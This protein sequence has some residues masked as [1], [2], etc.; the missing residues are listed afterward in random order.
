[1]AVAIGTAKTRGLYLSYLFIDSASPLAPAHSLESSH[2]TA[3][4]SFI[5]VNCTSFSDLDQFVMTFLLQIDSSVT[6]VHPKYCFAAILNKDKKWPIPH[7][8]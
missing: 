1:M 8:T 4:V 2:T 5:S 3:I 6:N 7:L